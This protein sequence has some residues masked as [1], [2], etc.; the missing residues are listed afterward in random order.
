MLCKPDPFQPKWP[1][2]FLPSISDPMPPIA[3]PWYKSN[4]TLAPPLRAWVP[5][6]RAPSRAPPCSWAHGPARP[7]HTSLGPARPPGCRP[8]RASLLPRTCSPSSTRSPDYPFFAFLL[9]HLLSAIAFMSSTLH[10]LHLLYFFFAVVV[11][12]LPWCAQASGSP[13]FFLFPIRFK[14]FY[15]TCT[16]TGCK[17]PHDFFS[18]VQYT[19]GIY[20]LCLVRGKK[21]SS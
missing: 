3:L 17:I 14:P 5:L 7:F 13:W 21:A 6:G 2:W 1:N 18:I 11:S 20:G 9:S 16:I 10:S 12:L 8:G 19:T 4:R 15:F